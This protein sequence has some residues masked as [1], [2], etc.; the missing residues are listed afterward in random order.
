[1]YSTLIIKN[2]II[3]VLH[4]YVFSLSL[5]QIFR[6]TQRST[7]K[8]PTAV[9]EMTAMATGSINSYHGNYL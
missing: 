5:N 1:M 9:L 4:D 2:T 7:Q 3:S 6:V 8:K